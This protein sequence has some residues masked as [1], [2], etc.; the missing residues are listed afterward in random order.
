[1]NLIL[2]FAGSNP[3]GSGFLERI[4]MV[5]YTSWM[6]DSI[7]FSKVYIWDGILFNL[8]LK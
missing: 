8:D 2:S 5:W 6:P 7:L 4:M 1:L 3:A